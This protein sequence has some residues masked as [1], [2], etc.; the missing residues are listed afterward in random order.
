MTIEMIRLN[1]LTKNLIRTSFKRRMKAKT[2]K[3]I[4]AQKVK[5]TNTI[6]EMQVIIFQKILTNLADFKSKYLANSKFENKRWSVNIN[7]TKENLN[8]N[9]AYSGKPPL[10]FKKTLNKN[11]QDSKYNSTGEKEAFTHADPIEFIIKKDQIIINNEYS[12]LPMKDEI[13]SFRLLSY[14]FHLHL[15]FKFLNTVLKK[16]KIRNNFEYLKIKNLNFV[17]TKI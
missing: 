16:T 12:N 9:D 13:Y 10:N 4:R 3:Q 17:K 2:Q 7:S 15:S 6:H 1:K 5:N 14:Y 8:H 11:T